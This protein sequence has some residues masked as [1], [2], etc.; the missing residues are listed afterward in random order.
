MAR[1]DEHQRIAYNNGQR[2]FK[3][4]SVA[5]HALT[6]YQSTFTHHDIA[7]FVSRHTSTPEQFKAVYEKVKT[8]PE[9][10]HLG[11][12]KVGKERYTTQA[13][14]DT[15]KHMVQQA[16]TK[17]N[18]LNHWVNSE[19]Q[20]KTLASNNLSE[21]QQAAFSHLMNSSDIAAVV[22]F[23]G[24]GKSHMLSAAKAAW[25]NM[26]GFRVKGM[27]LSGIAAENLEAASGIPSYT[28]ANRFIHW[29]NDREKLT[30]HDIIVIDE[31]GERRVSWWALANGKNSRRS[32][33]SKRQSRLNR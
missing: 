19:S 25:R 7:K 13:M 30:P 22:G 12:D 18:Q 15:E 14:I 6:Y 10:V 9:L 4:P 2:I 26:A 21:E 28:I 27:T 3:N 16:E 17:Q 24:T 33:T 31:A 11:Q 8:S 23:A 29:D 5:L 32:N 1:F 20:K